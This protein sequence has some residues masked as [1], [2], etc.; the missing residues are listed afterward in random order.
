MN[1]IEHEV[2]I[3]PKDII[4]GD[5]DGVVCLPQSL[6]TQVL[7]ILPRLVSGCALTVVFLR[8][9]DEKVLE[10]VSQGA[11]VKE[12]FQKYRAKT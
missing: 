5:A 6:A 9:A 8:L 4:I 7:E 2:W 10:E 3:R 11:S 12:S 1:G